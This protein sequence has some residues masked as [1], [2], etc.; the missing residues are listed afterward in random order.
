MIQEVLPKEEP[1]F[2]G[3][4]K[5]QDAGRSETQ[6]VVTTVSSLMTPRAHLTLENTKRA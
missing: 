5:H 6:R 4:L 3:T 1:D 2:V